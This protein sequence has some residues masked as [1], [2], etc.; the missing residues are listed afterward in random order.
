MSND[1]PMNEPINPSSYSIG[2]VNIELDPISAPGILT[3]V[4]YDEFVRRLF[5]QMDH[6]LMQCHAAMGVTGEAGEL[7]DAIKKHVIY[8]QD[9]DRDNIVEELGD[10]RFY[11]QAVM[12]IYGISET[13]VLQSNGIKLAKRYSGLVFTDKSAKLRLDKQEPGQEKK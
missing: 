6:K 11:I 1:T 10:L 3:L 13:E 9:L 4:R 12:N 7:A 5:K 8:N 2:F